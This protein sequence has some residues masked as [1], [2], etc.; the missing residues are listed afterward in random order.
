MKTVSWLMPPP[1][2]SPGPPSTSVQSG[3]P[4]RAQLLGGPGPLCPL[5]GLYGESG[6]PGLGVAWEKWHRH[7]GL[8]RAPLSHL[9]CGHGHW[10]L[11]RVVVAV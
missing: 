4:G 11:E 2:P 6:G 5:N 1:S 3:V 8:G 7:S 10:A 9:L